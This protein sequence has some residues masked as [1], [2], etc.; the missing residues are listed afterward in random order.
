MAFKKYSTVQL[1][2]VGEDIPEWV[3]EEK[4]KVASSETVDPE[5]KDKKD[6]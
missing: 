4:T 3:D 6:K 1:D 2:L 5:N